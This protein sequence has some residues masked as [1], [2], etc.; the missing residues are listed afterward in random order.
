MNMEESQQPQPFIIEVLQEVRKTVG[1]DFPISLR[2]SVEECIEGG[3]TFEDIRPI[4]PSLVQAGQTSSM[5]LLV[6]TEVR[7]GLRAPP[8]SINLGLMSGGLKS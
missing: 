2:L 6:R 7:V 4:L 1:P 8:L 3:Y 5:P